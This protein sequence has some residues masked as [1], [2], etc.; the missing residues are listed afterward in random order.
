MS[1]FQIKIS[2]K[3]SHSVNEHNSEVIDVHD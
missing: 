1:S 3:S 2:G